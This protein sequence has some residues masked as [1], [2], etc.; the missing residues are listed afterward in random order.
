MEE[1][2]APTVMVTDG[3][4]LADGGSLWIRISVDGQAQDYSLDRA[5]A[6]R[7]TPRYDSIRGARGVL[8]NEERRALRVLLERIAHRA[9]WAG[10]VDTFIQVLKRSDAS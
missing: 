9:M 1:N 5:L 7:G 3:A 8:S 2:T 10:I 6:S 4:A